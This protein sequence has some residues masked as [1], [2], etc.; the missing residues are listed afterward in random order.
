MFADF[1]CVS[2]IA[3]AQYAEYGSWR[4]HVSGKRLT[5][6]E[7]GA[8]STIPTVRR[9]SEQLAVAHNATLIRI[10]PGEPDGPPGT[11]EIPLPALEAIARIDAVLPK[12]FRERSTDEQNRQS[13]AASR[14]AREKFKTVAMKNPGVIYTTAPGTLKTRKMQKVYSKAFQIELP[15]GYVAWVDRIDI[16][17]MYLGYIEGL[18]RSDDIEQEINQ[19]RNFVATNFFGP[20]AVVL[21]PK[22]FDEKSDNPIMPPLRFAAQINSWET[23]DADSDGSWMNLIWFAEIDDD[24]SMKDFI[25]EALAQ[26]DWPTQASG[27]LI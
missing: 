15:S 18:P 17:R 8:G 7:L 19:A 10:N 25:A 4:K 22:L 23:L 13:A 16:K 2:D 12:Q 21:S 5:I 1:T 20:E 27:Y 24:K 9:E 14:M 3:D 26:V 11:V 6:I